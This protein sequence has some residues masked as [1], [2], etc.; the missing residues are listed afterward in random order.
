MG[1]RQ[2]SGQ[3]PSRNTLK[4]MGTHQSAMMLCLETEIYKLP[5]LLFVIV[6]IEYFST[7]TSL[8][9]GYVDGIHVFK[10]FHV[11]D[12]IDHGKQH[13]DGPEF[14]SNSSEHPQNEEVEH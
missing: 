13:H 10:I 9:Q 12:Q 1:K 2:C 4:R 8:C 7:D 5:D 14:G 6:L 3:R 11:D